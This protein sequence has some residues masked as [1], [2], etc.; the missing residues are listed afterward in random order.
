[1]LCL[2]HQQEDIWSEESMGG[3]DDADMGTW[4]DTAQQ[5]NSSWNSA[6]GWNK[7]RRNSIAKVYNC[8]QRHP[9]LLQA[10]VLDLPSAAFQYRWCIVIFLL[11]KF[12]A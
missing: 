5:N 2:P 3:W 4:N 12:E 10:R 7:D 11:S 1:M 8:S 9:K 6:T